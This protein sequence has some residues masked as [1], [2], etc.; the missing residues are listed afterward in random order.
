M[1]FTIQREKYTTQA[2]C[3]QCG[4][5]VPNRWQDKAGHVCFGSR[6]P[7]PSNDQITETQP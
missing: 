3:D 4:G 6:K 5:Q 1:T 7:S 2:R